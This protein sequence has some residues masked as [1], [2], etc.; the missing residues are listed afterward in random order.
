MS[1]Y[2]PADLRREVARRAEHCCEYCRAQERF[3]GDL[4]TVDHVVPVALGGPT[5]SDNLALSCHGCNQHKSKRTT[6]ADPATGDEAPL[7][8]PRHERWEEHFAW[9]EDFTLVLG[10]TPTGRASVAALRLN[11]VGL[12]NLRR[13]LYAINEHPPRPAGE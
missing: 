7:F 9:N 10:L 8:N 4:L 3:S 6:A 12:V 13:V 2:V 5:V 11:R 1:E